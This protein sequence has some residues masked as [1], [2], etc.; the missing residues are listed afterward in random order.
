MMHCLAHFLAGSTETEVLAL[1]VR[2]VA[3]RLALLLHLGGDV[4]GA[5]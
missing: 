5:A 3:G 1:P 2:R 4:L